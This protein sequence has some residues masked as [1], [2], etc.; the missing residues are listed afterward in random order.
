[1]TMLTVKQALRSK[2]LSCDYQESLARLHALAKS[3]SSIRR[4]AL[5]LA[6]ILLVESYNRPRSV[7]FLEWCASASLRNHR[8]TRGPYQLRNSPW[9]F[10][11][12]T[13]RAI[14]SLEES[15]CRPLGER[16]DCNTLAERWNSTSR[17]Q[18]GSA[19]GYADAL[20]AALAVCTDGD[21]LHLN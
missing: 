8:M 6:A 12:A 2:S 9:S 3:D 19:I 7:R 20:R 11:R 15:G 5:T 16:E 1:M 21:L 10:R 18:P 17:R 13:R 4:W 14:K